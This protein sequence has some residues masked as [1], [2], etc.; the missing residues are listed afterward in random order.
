MHELALLPSL[1]QSPQLTPSLFSSFLLFQKITYSKTL[2]KALIPASQSTAPGSS[3][4]KI[5]LSTA[6]READELKRSREEDDTIRERA[7]KRA[8]GEEVEGDEPTKEEE[9]DEDDMDMDE[10]DDEE[11][12]FTSSLGW[13]RWGGADG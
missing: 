9:A 2:S 1:L 10:E 4:S 13:V 6:Q 12:E 3:A 8:R 11:G 5:V 7:D